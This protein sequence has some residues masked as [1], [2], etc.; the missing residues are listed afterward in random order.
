MVKTKPVSVLLPERFGPNEPY[1]FGTQV[2][3]ILQS[4][5]PVQFPEDS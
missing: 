4:P 1:T 5:L 2:N 3:G